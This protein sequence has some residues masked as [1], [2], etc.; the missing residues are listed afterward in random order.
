M[1]FSNDELK[2]L[3]QDVLARRAM[4]R[5]VPIHPD[6]AYYGQSILSLIARLEAAEIVCQSIID[7]G[8]EKNFKF[9]M[10]AWRKTAGKL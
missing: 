10:K 9:S 3:K 5:D 1:T 7:N 6:I 8:D 4:L 2:R